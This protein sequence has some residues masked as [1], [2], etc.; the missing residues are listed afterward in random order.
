V[1]QTNKKTTQLTKFCSE[2]QITRHLIENVFH[3][4]L[5]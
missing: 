4:K 5:L 2:V 1:E 3:K